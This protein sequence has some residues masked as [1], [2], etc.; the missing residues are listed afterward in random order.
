MRSSF[1][2]YLLI[3][4]AGGVVLGGCVEK[5]TRAGITVETYSKVYR[6]QPDGYHCSDIINFLHRPA[7]VAIYTKNP[8]F[9]EFTALSFKELSLWNR[10][11]DREY[12]NVL[13][14]CD[15]IEN[16][17]RYLEQNIKYNAYDD[18]RI[19]TVISNAMKSR[20]SIGLTW[21]GG[22]AFTFTD[23]RYAE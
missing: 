11:P 17:P 3:V 19:V 1:F 18:D 23:Y 12:L 13:D 15:F 20:Q 21:D 5:K 14:L 4:I 2:L 8:A 6:Q 16:A 9:T 10:P 7:F 22:I